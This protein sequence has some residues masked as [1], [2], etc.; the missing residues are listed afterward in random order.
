MNI[1]LVYLIIRSFE[2]FDLDGLSIKPEHYVNCYVIIGC[3]CNKDG[4]LF[5]LTNNLNIQWY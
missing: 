5:K 1:I 4:K 3:C 2:S